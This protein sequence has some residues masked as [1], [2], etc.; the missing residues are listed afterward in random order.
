MSGLF[1]VLVL[2]RQKGLEFP[3]GWGYCKAKIFK[4]MYIIWN[5][6]RGVGVLAKIPSM[7]FKVWIFSGNTQ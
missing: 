1:I 5:F 6:Q 4:E 7:G 2:P 3:G